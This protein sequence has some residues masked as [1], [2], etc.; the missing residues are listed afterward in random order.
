MSNLRTGVRKGVYW[1]RGSRAV[2]AG[3]V[4]CGQSRGLTAAAWG[5]IASGRGPTHDHRPIPIP[6][7]PLVR[8]A[9]SCARPRCSPPVRADRARRRT[10]AHTP[11]TP[12]G[13]PRHTCFIR[14]CL[15]RRFTLLCCPPSFVF[16]FW[17]FIHVLSGRGLSLLAPAMRSTS[18]RYVLLTIPRSMKP[19]P[20]LRRR[21]LLRHP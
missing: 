6:V 7:Q 13:V 1:G 19:R 9:S 4:G 14:R 17:Q 21:D 2:V 3:V 15:S 5:I 8:V 12:T 20:A 16:P 18:C 10:P 11:P